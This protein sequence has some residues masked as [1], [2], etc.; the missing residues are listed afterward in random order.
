MQVVCTGWELR[1]ELPHSRVLVM[2]IWF[3]LCVPAFWEGRDGDEPLGRA[4]HNW[5]AEGELAAGP[6]LPPRARVAALEDTGKGREVGEHCQ[7]GWPSYC[8]LLW[9]LWGPGQA[10]LLPTEKL[11]L[12]QTDVHIH[13]RGL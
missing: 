12:S 4:L 13:I 8:G 9:W 1:I 7:T 11:H 10:L 2:L 6:P 3:L 5:E